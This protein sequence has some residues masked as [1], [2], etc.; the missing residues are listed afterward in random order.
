MKNKKLYIGLLL[1]FLGLVFIGFMAVKVVPSVFVT[2]TKAAPATKVSLGNSYLLGD[3]ILAKADGI[4]KC[5]VNVFVLDSS[6]KGVKG[7]RVNLSGMPSGEMEG[8]SD[9]NGKAAF[10]I[11]SLTEGQFTLTGSI[12]GVSLEKTLKITFRNED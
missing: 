5:T 6:D 1:G 9:N 12:N 2:L 10:E 11:S 3:K 7:M 8:L 4:E